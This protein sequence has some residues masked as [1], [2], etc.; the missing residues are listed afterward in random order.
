MVK[1]SFLNEII[2][3]QLIVLFYNDNWNLNILNIFLKFNLK[4]SFAFKSC[5]QLKTMGK[6]I[7]AKQIVNYY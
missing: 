1:C 6:Q 5:I 4:K 3:Q 7:P 2:L